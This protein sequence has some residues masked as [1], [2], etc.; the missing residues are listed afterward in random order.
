LTKHAISPQKIRLA[1]ITSY[2]HSGYGLVYNTY[3]GT[4]AI[5][6]YTSVVTGGIK[7]DLTGYLNKS[8]GNIIVCQDQTGAVCVL[9]QLLGLPV[10]CYTMQPFG[11]INETA[12]V[13]V[14]QC[15]NPCFNRSD[16]TGGQI[17]GCNEIEFVRSGFVNHTFVGY[18]NLIYDATIGPKLGVDKNIYLQTT[19]DRSTIDERNVA[20]NISNVL[21]AYILKLN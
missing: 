21:Y 3:G 19:I 17:T 18:N 14:G 6:L 10:T 8:H 2:L 16:I 9:G 1:A 13:G 4:N 11:Y 5:S 7:V 12:L 15:N 20:G